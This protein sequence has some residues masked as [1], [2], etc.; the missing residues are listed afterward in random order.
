[1]TGPAVLAVIDCGLVDSSV[2]P[3]LNRPDTKHM[4]E[5][6]RVFHMRRAV[7]D[8]IETPCSRS[9]FVCSRARTRTRQRRATGFCGVC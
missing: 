1:M 6:A 5:D 4:P 7:A 3:E 2:R 8:A 9:R